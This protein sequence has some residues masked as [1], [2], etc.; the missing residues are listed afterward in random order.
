VGK[1]LDDRS[2][3]NMSIYQHKAGLIEYAFSQDQ[4]IVK[5]AKIL[6]ICRMTLAREIE[7]VR[8]M[9]IPMTGVPETARGDRSRRATPASPA[10]TTA[11]PAATPASPAATPVVADAT[12]AAPAATPVV[13][14]AT[15][16]APA[17][18]PVVADATPA[19]DAVPHAVADATPDAAP[20]ATPDAVAD[21]QALGVP[22][23]G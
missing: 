2:V 8:G 12:P 6:G 23:A 9:G 7:T 14:D 16:A 18:T 13:A 1:R 5:A 4:N 3:W 11:S 21:A 17:A 20:D 22:L 10:A 15:P 19:A